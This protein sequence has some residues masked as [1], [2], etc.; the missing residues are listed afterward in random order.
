VSGPALLA[1]LLAAAPGVPPP[2]GAPAAALP[3]GTARYR[4]IL[5]GE[6]VGL[7]ELSL[8][9]DGPVCRAAWESRQRLPAE[10]GGGVR[11]HRI[12][13][14]VDRAGRSRGPARHLDGG[15]AREV[16]LPEGAV[17][18]M[19]AEVA[20]L[21]A[22][23]GLAPTCLAAADERSGAPIQACAR[24]QGAVLEATVGRERERIQPGQ[25]G[26]AAEVA[27]PAQRVVFRLDAE[28]Q[29]PASA[30]R[31]FGTAVAG[32]EDSR[33]ARAFCGVGRDPELAAGAGAGLPAPRAPGPTCREQS[34][35]WLERARSAGWRGRTAVGVAWDGGGYVWHAW[36]EVH[37]GGRWVPVDPAFHQSPARGPRFTL[38]TWAPGDEAGRAEAGR[39]ILA[40]WGRAAVA[41]SAA[42]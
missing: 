30:P 1:F 17:P 18:A 36:A 5:G 39:R 13:V 11:A 32:P 6:P 9:C 8:R 34:A 14:P 23:P 19:L 3:E 27:L 29:L 41:G 31:L 2:A 37:A 28:V 12:E 7:V 16:A 38:A 4:M 22:R 26:F 24:R 10:A 20:L 40:C 33:D 25:G 21:A 42:R 15:E 35:A